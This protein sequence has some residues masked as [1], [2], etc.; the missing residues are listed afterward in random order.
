MMKLLRKGKLFFPILL[1]IVSLVP[2]L[3]FFHP[4]L[5]LT[6]DGQD[7]VAR[8]ANFYAN[9]QQGNITPHWAGNLNWGYGHPILMFLYPLPSYLASLFH[10]FGFSFIDSTKIVF[11]IAYILSGLSMYLWLKVFLSKPA[12]AIGGALYLFAPYRFVELYVRGDIGEHVAFIFPP[13]VLY[14]LLKLSRKNSFVSLLGGSLSFAGLI[15]A[16][17]AMS[18]M[19]LPIILIYAAYLFYLVKFNR[20]FIISVFSLILLGFGFSAFFWIPAFFE[21]KYTLRNIVTS[22][23]AFTRFVP[24]V[25]YIYSPWSY[26]QTG[27]FSVQVGIIHWIAVLS[28]IP[29]LGYYYKKKNI[30][31]LLLIGLLII[32]IISFFIMLPQSMF[33]W[34]KVTL[35]Q[36]FQ[37]PWRFIAVTVFTTSVMGALAFS[38]IQ[39]KKQFSIAITLAILILLINKDYSHANGYLYKPENFFTGIYNGTTDTGESSPVWS[40]RFMEQRPKAH[41]VLIGGSAKIKEQQRTITKH[42]YSVNVDNK[43]QLQEN[44][45]YFPGWEIFVDNKLVPIEYQDPNNRGLMTFYIE[46]GLHNVVVTFGETRLRLISDYLSIFSLFALVILGILRK[47]LWQS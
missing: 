44:T 6:H 32:F 40:V 18:L 14:F 24:F 35:L 11:G 20:K 16:H 2:L 13:L 8:I 27:E 42:I 38:F 36:N 12:S 3:D 46:K 15:L 43:A 47:R 9:L 23:V 37:F 10:A 4:G 45:L 28:G 30:N 5:P 29:L 31:F 26:G 39:E 22:G 7:H 21:G 33:L 19:F 17:N 25:K 34:E 41:I 1:V